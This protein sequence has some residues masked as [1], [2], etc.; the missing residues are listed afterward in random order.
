MISIMLTT[1]RLEYLERVIKM[2]TEQE[3]RK[4]YERY[5]KEMAPNNAFDEGFIEGL[6]FALGILV[7]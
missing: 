1:S 3:I 2:R 7:D 6:E 4:E 5:K